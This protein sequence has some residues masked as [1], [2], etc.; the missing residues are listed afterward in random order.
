VIS[1][2]VESIEVKPTGLKLWTFF[3]RKA[4]F[5]KEVRDLVLNY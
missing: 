2:N 5:N 1:W 3:N 4:L